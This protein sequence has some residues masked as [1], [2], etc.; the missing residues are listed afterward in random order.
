METKRFVKLDTDYDIELLVSS[1]KKTL[2]KLPAN[3]WIVFLHIGYIGFGS[4]LLGILHTSFRY[5]YNCGLCFRF[6]YLKA[7][8]DY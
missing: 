3:A 1:A 5:R 2:K 6:P 8:E 7:T 4:H